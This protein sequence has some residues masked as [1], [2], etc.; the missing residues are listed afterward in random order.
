MVGSVGSGKSSFVNAL[1]GE[2]NKISGHINIKGKVAYAPQ[3][4]WIQNGSIREN[5]LFGLPYDR[6][7]YQRVIT[8]CCLKSDFEQL[9]DG[10]RTEIGENYKL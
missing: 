6:A 3:Q 8:L 5:I 9:V 7:F 10:D 4:P 2:L 1:I